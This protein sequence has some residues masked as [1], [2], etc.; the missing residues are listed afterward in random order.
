MGGQVKGEMGR[1]TPRGGGKGESELDGKKSYWRG[2]CTNTGLPTAPSTAS[3]PVAR[4]EEEP[5]PFLQKWMF[6]SQTYE[7]RR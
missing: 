3:T 4:L 2:G 5:N 7:K 6:V 1:E